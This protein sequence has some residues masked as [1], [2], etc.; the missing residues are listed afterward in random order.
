MRQKRLAALLAARQ[1]RIHPRRE[2]AIRGVSPG[3]AHRRAL[4]RYG[5]AP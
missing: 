5:F 4:A 2:R 3:F 1:R